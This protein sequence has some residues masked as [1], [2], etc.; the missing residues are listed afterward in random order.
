MKSYKNILAPVF[1]IIFC[2]HLYSQSERPGLYNDYIKINENAKKIKD[3]KISKRTSILI[4]GSGNDTTSVMLYDMNGNLSKSTTLT[5]NITDMDSRVFYLKYWY[6]Y[7]GNGKL[8]ERIDSTGGQ[9]RKTKL[10]YD[11]MGNIVKEEMWDGFNNVL[12]EKSH[13][14]DNL[15]RLIESS[16]KNIAGNCRIVKQYA[17]DS[18]NNMAKYNI[19]NSCDASK[20][21]VLTYVYK[22]DKR[23]NIIEKNSLSAASNYRT[24]SFSYGINGNLTQSYIITGDGRYTLSV[25]HYD[26]SNVKAKV[27]RTDV[28][29]GEKKK[30]TEL[31][32]YDNFGNI[33]EIKELDE[34]GNQTFV[35][36]YIYEFYN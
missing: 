8:V 29:N 12:M 28:N 16:E 3:A 21:Q 30:Y 31:Y 36:K 11:D 23:S 15:G 24:E 2:A 26:K 22:Y 20:N 5:E 33:L 7:D 18:Y 32:S 17:Y 14:Y 1:L 35:T 9:F 34:E 25:Y 19:K 4:G 13:E 27:E 6:K 10:S